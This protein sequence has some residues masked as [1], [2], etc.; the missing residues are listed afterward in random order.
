MSTNNSSF[1]FFILALTW[2]NTYCCENSKKCPLQSASEF[3]S[4]NLI[5]HGLWP[6][7]A[8]GDYPKNCKKVKRNLDRTADLPLLSKDL[9]P[10]LL[11]DGGSFAEH[12]YYKHGTCIDR[13]STFHEYFSESMRVMYSIPKT[14][15]GTPAVISRNVGKKVALSE[16]KDAFD[17]KVAIACT[18][19]CQLK[20]VFLCFEKR[21]DGLVGNA[22]DCSKDI[23]K[24]DSCSKNKCKDVYINEFGKCAAPTT[25]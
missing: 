9:S 18:N 7:F 23:L 14:T 10:G 12:E 24:K 22:I 1:D 5:L 4:S 8:N 20:E 21:R 2:A 25:Q 6:T 11:K 15:K 16:L 13:L 17:K 19:A 3:G